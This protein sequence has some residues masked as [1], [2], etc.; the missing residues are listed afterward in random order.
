MTR[1]SNASQV[2]EHYEMVVMYA[3]LILG[4]DMKSENITAKTKSDDSATQ[5]AS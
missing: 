4:C 3:R 1:N 5:V 2:F